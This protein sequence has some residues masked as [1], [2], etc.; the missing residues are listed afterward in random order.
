MKTK[1]LSKANFFYL[2]TFIL[3]LIFLVFVNLI[4][5]GSVFNYLIFFI[6]L[7]TC[8]LSSTFLFIRKIKLN[9]LIS[10]FLIL[11]TL[12]L[13]FHLLSILNLVLLSAIFIFL[14][15]RI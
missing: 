11:L 12:L 9:L 7:F 10:F 8:F 6:L 1:L 13:F 2:T 4:S 14:G 3:W 15:F 5:P